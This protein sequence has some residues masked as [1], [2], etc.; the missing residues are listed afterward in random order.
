LD[1]PTVYQ[2]EQRRMLAVAALPSTQSGAILQM[3]LLIALRPP[4]LMPS[5][6][7]RIGIR[8]A[9]SAYLQIRNPG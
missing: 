3:A 9:V 6:S 1:H 4:A 7:T 5:N 2:V 8:L